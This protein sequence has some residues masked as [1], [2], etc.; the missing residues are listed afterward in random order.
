M[1]GAGCGARSGARGGLADVKSFDE[2][3]VTNTELT[4][5]TGALGLTGA[6]PTRIAAP[7]SFLSVGGSGVRF[8]LLLARSYG[9]TARP[10]RNAW[11]R[12]LIS[13]S[14]DALR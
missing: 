13:T 6:T 3:L 7:T 5:D 8:S 9:A 10:A 12:Y 11:R 2:W 1:T 4:P 14:P